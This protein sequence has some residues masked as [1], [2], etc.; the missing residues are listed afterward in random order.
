MAA[1]KSNIKTSLLP[2]CYNR[3]DVVYSINRF[4]IIMEVKLISKGFPDA[5]DEII[6]GSPCVCIMHYSFL[7]NLFIRMHLKVIQHAA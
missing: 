3:G 1:V 6:E 2:I 4:P 7:V 5:G